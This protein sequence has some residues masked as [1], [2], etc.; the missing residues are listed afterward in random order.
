MEASDLANVMSIEGALTAAEARLL[1]N[2]AECIRDG[3][4]V[5]IGSWRGRSTAALAYGARAGYGVPVYAVDPHERFHDVLGG[6]Y[7]GSDDRA[8]FMQNILRFGLSDIVRLVNLSSECIASWPDVVGLLWVDGDHRYI[9]VKRDLNIWLPYLRPDATIVFHDSTNPRI[10]PFHAIAELI[11][12]GQWERHE[13]VD[14]AV[15]LR[16]KSLPG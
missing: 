15:M 13:A 12:S 6:E 2:A 11:A 8:A 1:Y 5:E 14:K 10:G 16:R 9:G 4:I 3:C 7:F